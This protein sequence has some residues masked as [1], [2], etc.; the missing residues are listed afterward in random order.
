MM[1]QDEFGSA[2]SYGGVGRALLL[3]ARSPQAPCHTCLDSIP[4]S[5]TREEK[6]ILLLL[7]RSISDQPSSQLVY[8]ESSENK[9]HSEGL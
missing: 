3:Q 9:D 7:P 4:D 5:T 2:T 1:K 6:A 8:F